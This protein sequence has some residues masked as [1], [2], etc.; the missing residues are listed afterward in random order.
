MNIFAYLED[1]LE[2]K[3]I[4]ETYRGAP[5]TDNC[6]EWVYFDCILA[7]PEK[8][9]DRLG[10]DKQILKIHSLLGTHEGTEQGLV[11]TKCH[12]AIM[13]LHPEYARQ[14]KKEAIVHI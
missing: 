2:E 5:W 10:M 11:C 6:R 7:D 12:D 3:R 13:G 4:K 1:E 9:M 14:N 8:T